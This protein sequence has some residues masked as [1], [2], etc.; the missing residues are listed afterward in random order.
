ML[1]YSF[2]PEV[3]WY[4]WLF[5]SL[6]GRILWTAF[7]QGLGKALGP[8]GGTLCWAAGIGCVGIT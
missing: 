3:I 2:I 6:Y 8:L 4:A 1:R 7:S 5:L